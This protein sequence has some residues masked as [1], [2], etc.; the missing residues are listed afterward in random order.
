MTDTRTALVDLAVLRRRFDEAADRHPESAVFNF[1]ERAAPDGARRWE[2]RTDSRLPASISLTAQASLLAPDL[3]A[4]AA[5]RHPEPISQEALSQVALLYSV[6]LPPAVQR[7]LDLLSRQ[8]IPLLLKLGEQISKD[9]RTPGGNLLEW[10]VGQAE[11]SDRDVRRKLDANPFRA[12]ACAIQIVEAPD[13]QTKNEVS[14]KEMAIALTVNSP[15]LSVAEIAEKVGV[16]RTTPY[17][18][19]KFMS[20]WAGLQAAH[21]SASPPRGSKGRDGILEAIDD[22]E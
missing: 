22:T 20:L 10:V 2:L 16:A 17:K 13:V 4:Q 8:A 12:I 9:E 5:L 6:P 7:D 1:I 3:M 14:N 11:P 21:A 18:W 15:Y 19:P